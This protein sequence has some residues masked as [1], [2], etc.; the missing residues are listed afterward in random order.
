MQK[1]NSG[2]LKAPKGSIVIPVDWLRAEVLV[3]FNDKQRTKV[4]KQLGLLNDAVFMAST[5]EIG[6]MAHVA[7]HNGLCKFLLFLPFHDQ[8]A[9]V[10]ECTHMVHMLCDVHGIP[11]SMDNT[12]TIAY[13][14]GHLFEAVK[15]YLDEEKPHEK[16]S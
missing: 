5:D 11:I 12:E 7:S 16:N 3:F 6:G 15:S 4:A 1:K 9:L 8:G 14:T 10:H 2:N 13:M